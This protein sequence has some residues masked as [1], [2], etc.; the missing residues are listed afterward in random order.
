[1]PEIKRS[2]RSLKTLYR[3]TALYG[4]EWTYAQVAALEPDLILLD[5]HMPEEGGFEL[6]RQ[7]RLVGI[8]QLFGGTLEADVAVLQRFDQILCH[9]FVY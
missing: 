5:V 8:R 1:M 9:C 4:S 6:C 7:L 3:V 2:E